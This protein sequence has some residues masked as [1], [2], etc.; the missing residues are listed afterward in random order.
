[1]AMTLTILLDDT[2]AIKVDG[3]I[4]NPLVCYGLLACAQDAIRNHAAQKAA[5][6]IQPATP[7]EVS[8]IERTLKLQ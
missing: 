7:A 1:M 3:P 8:K 5:S 6:P 2:G 4:D